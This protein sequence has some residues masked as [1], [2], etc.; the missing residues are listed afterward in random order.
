[1]EAKFKR[2]EM[3]NALLKKVLEWQQIGRET[4]EGSERFYYRRALSF[5]C[6]RVDKK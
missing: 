5:Q 3:E 4:Y 2:L 6:Y 1:M